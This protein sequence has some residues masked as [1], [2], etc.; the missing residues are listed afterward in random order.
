MPATNLFRRLKEKTACRVL[1]M[2]NVIPP[3]CKPTKASVKA[4]WTSAGLKPK[5]TAH[6]IEID[7][8]G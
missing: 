2:D 1:Q 3:E 5:V 6:C 7:I 8:A 4:A